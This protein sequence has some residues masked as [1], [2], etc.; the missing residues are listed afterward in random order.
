LIVAF[1][2][3]EFNHLPS[4]DLNWS[5]PEQNANG[6][7]VYHLKAFEFENKVINAIVL[8]KQISDMNDVKSEDRITMRLLP[9]GTKHLV[10]EPAVSQYM[11]LWYET[12]FCIE[13]Y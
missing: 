12:I 9:C 2:P 1:F 7:V 3:S 5:R 11:K 6:F 10:S 13:Q 8:T 4:Y